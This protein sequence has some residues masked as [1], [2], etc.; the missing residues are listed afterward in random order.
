MMIPA[1]LP[2]YERY[3]CSPDLRPQLDIGACV[4]LAIPALQLHLRLHDF[5]MGIHLSAWF[6]I[7]LTQYF[8]NVTECQHYFRMH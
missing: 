3:N 8:R 6:Y 4:S 2:G 1:G 7:H 5:L